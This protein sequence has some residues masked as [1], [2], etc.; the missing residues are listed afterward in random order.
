MLCKPSTRTTPGARCALRSLTSFDRCSAYVA[1]VRPPGRPLAFPRDSLRSLSTLA[2]SP[3]PSVGWPQLAGFV[4]W[5]A[6]SGLPANARGMS[7]EG[8]KLLRG[9]QTSGL[10]TIAGE[11]LVSRANEGSSGLVSDG[12]EKRSRLGRGWPRCCAVSEWLV[13]H[14]PHRN[15]AVCR[16]I[17]YESRATIDRAVQHC[18]GQTR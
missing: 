18:K 13:W 6:M 14:L 15:S 5:R 8:V 2:L 17:K 7:T 1:R 4:L 12:V 11:V 10:L 3:P 9:S 16:G